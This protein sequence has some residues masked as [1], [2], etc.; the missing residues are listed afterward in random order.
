VAIAKRDIVAGP[1]E[2]KGH[3]LADL[4]QLFLERGERKYRAQQVYDA[5]YIHRIDDVAGMHV[6]PQQLRDTLQSDYRTS[7]VRLQTVQQSEDGTKKFLFELHD[8]RAV[9]SVLIPSEMRE[10]DGVP[11]RLTLCVSTQVGCNLGCV[12]C[13]TASLKLTR[14]LTSGEIVDQFLQAQKHSEKPITNIVFMGMGEPMNNYDAVMRATQIFNDQRTKMVAPRRTTLSTAGVIPGIIRMAD[15]GQI[16]K[17]AVSLHA[18]TQDVRAELMPIAKKYTLPELIEAL[19]YYYRATRK[20]VTYEYILFDGINDSIDD[21]RR[22]GKLARRMPTKI[23][24]IPFHDIDF[25][26][27]QGF[28][29]TLKPSPAERFEWFLQKLREED[30]Q[31]LVRSSSGVD[32]DAACGQLAFSTEQS[33]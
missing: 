3:P 29:K 18:T 22:L 1:P 25:T 12:F 32:I 14:N 24:V 23:N 17:L 11:R 20:S 31:V 19:E 2:L 27:P 9:E 13:A 4:E 10:A 8:G 15:E 6:L 33:A 16:I 21:V 28:A 30:V 5:L 7:S 26:Q